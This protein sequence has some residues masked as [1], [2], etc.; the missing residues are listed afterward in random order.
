MLRQKN[1][2]R[3]ADALQPPVG[4][5]KDAD[6][7]DRAIAVL[8]RPDQAEAGVRVA[9]EIEHGIHDVFEHARPG[10]RALLGHV[11]DQNHRDAGLFGQPGQ[12]RRAFAHLR[13][14]ARRRTELLRPQRLD[15][16]DHRHLRLRSLQ[17]GEDLFQIDLGQQ[18]AACRYSSAS[19]RARIATC[20]PDSSPLT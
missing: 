1:R 10:Q 4:H 14:R 6:F 13:H 3:V 8:D 17:R 15:R 11:A 9:L 12:L 16:V 7:V 20:W 5:G 19:R 18:F 2:R